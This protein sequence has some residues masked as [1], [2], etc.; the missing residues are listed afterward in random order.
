MKQQTKTTFPKRF[1]WGVATSAHQ[2]E[3]GTDNQWT[4]WEQEHAKRLAAQAPYAL[5]Q[6][7]NWEAI[8][9]RAQD[10]Q[11]YLSGEAVDHY[12]RYKEDFAIAKK[13]GFDSFRC[14]IEWSRIEPSEGAWDV[15]AIDHYKAYFTAMKAAGLT[16]V[17]TLFHFTLP[18][19]F[20][21]KGGFAKSS[22]LE[23]FHRFVDKVMDEFGTALKYI[24]TINEP[25]IY[26]EKGYREGSW[27][28]G[29]QRPAEARRV[30]RNLAR[31]HRQ[32]AA[33]IHARNRRFKVSVA[34]NVSAIYPGDDARLSIQ[35]AKIM[36]RLANQFFLDR[37]YKHCDFIG[38]NYYFANR[39]YGYRVHNPHQRTSDVGWDMQ[40]ERIGEV[41]AWLGE[42]YRLPIMV[43]EN[44]LADEADA[45]REWWIKQT[46][47]AIKEA[48]DEGVTVIG[49]LH[50]SL[51]DNFE[52]E[53][54]FWPKFGLVAV[55]RATMKRTVRPSGRWMMKLLAQ[56]KQPKE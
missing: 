13:I 9:R 21:D 17:V 26:A 30:L 34:M 20:A 51:L 27:P 8:A 38:L 43:T 5:K 12:H 24:I 18:A 31:A 37:V 3:G 39:V 56:L 11:N 28:P 1:L 2:V 41:L 22:N 40:P 48:L 44:G 25:T 55:D 45:Q 52:W 32:A 53:K 47:L 33:L 35:S 36:H 29:V 10:Y 54:G 46:L 14:S 50:W 7:D 19:W 6:L 42:R 15:E 49:Y 23:H 4:R 16:P